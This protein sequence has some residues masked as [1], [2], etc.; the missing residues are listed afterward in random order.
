MCTM[1]LCS[2]F[3]FAQEMA[4]GSFLD[5][6][7]MIRIEINLKESDVPVPGL[8]MECCYGY[9]QGNINGTWAI[10]KV[11]KLDEKMALVR[12]VSDKGDV[13]QD[14]EFTFTEDGFTMKQVGDSFIKAIENRKY[15]KLPKVVSFFK[16]K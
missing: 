2:V 14:I 1:I 6:K 10:L 11:K 15:V 13:A 16:Q 8:E 4:K 7:R 9:I 3:S 5:E 12:A